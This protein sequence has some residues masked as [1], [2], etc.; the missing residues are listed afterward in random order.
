[1]ESRVYAEDPTKFM[2]SI[3]RVNT[4]IESNGS[5]ITVYYD[6]M[7]AKLCT[8]NTNRKEALAHMHRFLLLSNKITY[9]Y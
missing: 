6:P 4:Y 2:P 9:L 8:Y 7:I 3:G 1:M 5:E